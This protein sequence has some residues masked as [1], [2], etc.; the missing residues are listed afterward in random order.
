MSSAREQYSELLALTQI[1]LLQEY[2]SKEWIFSDSEAFRYFKAL[3][4][5]KRQENKQ[6]PQ[7]IP[8]SE[9]AP[10]EK[11]VR[12][13]E[14][15]KITP[16]PVVVKEDK[17]E[18]IK[19]VV[20]EEKKEPQKSKQVFVPEPLAKAKE[21]DLS[22]MRAAVS[23]AMPQV[24]IADTP[25]AASSPSIVL[26]AL[27]ETGEELLFLHNVASAIDRLLKPAEVVTLAKKER[28]AAWKALLNRPGL[29]WIIAFGEEVYTLP[30]I[31]KGKQKIGEIS[32]LIQPAASAILRDPNQK[33]ALWKLLKQILK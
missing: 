4:E 33:T 1:F 19:P 31:V 27:G 16:E 6:K 14:P 20:M 7:I 5:S 15:P 21:I 22:D 29:S 17:I 25:K 11:P 24:K 2:T 18:P 28:E 10:P 3:E 32:L 12:P 23:N 26:L 13:P 9:A 30:G 8:K